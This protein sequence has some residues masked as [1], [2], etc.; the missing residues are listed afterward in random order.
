MTASDRF[1]GT[2]PSKNSPVDAFGRQVLSIFQRAAI[3]TPGLCGYASNAE[4]TL[5]FGAHVLANRSCF[6]NAPKRLARHTNQDRSAILKRLGVTTQYWPWH[7]SGSQTIPQS[8]LNKAAVKC[9]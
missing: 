7:F 1:I 9:S 4:F 2:Q 3:L 6:P 5:A 8:I